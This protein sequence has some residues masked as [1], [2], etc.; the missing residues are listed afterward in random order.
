MAY[1]KEYLDRLLDMED[2]LGHNV[3]ERIDKLVE[4]RFMNYFKEKEKAVNSD[5]NAT[6]SNKFK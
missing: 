6:T 1:A 5:A 2:M 3:N 4:Q